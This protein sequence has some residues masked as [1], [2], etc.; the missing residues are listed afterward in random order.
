MSHK[1]NLPSEYLQEGWCQCTTSLDEHGNKIDFANKKSTEWC[2][3]G[4]IQAA[5][6]GT[7]DYFKMIEELKRI[8]PGNHI[9]KWNDKQNQTKENIIE[10]V[11]QAEYNLGIS[12]EPTKQQITKKLSEFFKDTIKSIY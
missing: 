9:S 1:Y 2:A 8:V 3:M 4:A 6:I 7:D 11:R 5:L 12:H 10:I